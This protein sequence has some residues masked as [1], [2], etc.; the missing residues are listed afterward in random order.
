MV[1]GRNAASADPR[2]GSQ[3]RVVETLSKHKQILARVGTG[4]SKGRTIKLYAA[5]IVR[6]TLLFEQARHR[7][8]MRH[9]FTQLGREIA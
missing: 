2:F 4:G 7:P 9:S 6:A 5:G 8:A 3:D 1:A